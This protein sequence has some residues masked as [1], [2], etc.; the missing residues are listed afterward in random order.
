MS[1]ALRI[2]LA[3]D[4]VIVRAGVETLIETFAD[5]D[6]VGTCDSLG[7]LLHAVEEHRPDVVLTDIRMPPSHTDEGVLA[8]QTLRTTHP[9][10]GVV[11]LSQYVDPHL[12][13]AVLEAGSRGRG[14]LIKEHVADAGKLADALRAVGRGGSFI[15]TDVLDAL[16]AGRAGAT[17]SG[18]A[19]LTARELDVL[20]HM[21]EG[22]SNASIGEA[23]F[24]G[25]RAVEKHIGSIFSKLELSTESDRHRRVAAVVAYLAE[26]PQDGS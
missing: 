7:G 24:I 15:D 8:A 2:V 26:F 20:G 16:V 13:L 6:V 10:V 9:D 23:L 12:A 18:L 5:I 21:A 4:D 22:R 17:D 25:E 19:G 3:D 1:R 14:Y 11:V